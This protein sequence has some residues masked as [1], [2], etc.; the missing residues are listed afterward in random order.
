MP[1]LQGLANED[2]L[3]VAAGVRDPAELGELPGNARVAPF[4]PFAALLPHVAVYVTNRGYGGVQQALA[5]GI[6]VVSAGTTE[7]KAEVGGRVEYAGVG[8]NLRTNTPTPEQVRG[9]VVALLGEGPV[10]QRA[11]ALGA[12]MRR[13]DAPR[14]AATLVETLAQTGRRVVDTARRGPCGTTP[15]S[16]PQWT[17]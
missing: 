2:V 8:I 12:E 5:H 9:S 6:P 10:R 17:P 4:L 11:R 13:H 15:T 3:V 7:D 16:P 1:T 14:E